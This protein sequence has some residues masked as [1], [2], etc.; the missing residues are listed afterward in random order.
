MPVDVRTPSTLVGTM[1]YLSE[2]C[3]EGGISTTHS[4]I[5]D[6]T[7]AIR[8]DFTLQNY[9]GPEAVYCHELIARF[10]IVSLHLLASKTG[11]E[12]SQEMEQLGKTLTSLAGFYNAKHREFSYYETEPEFRAY[13]IIM[14][15]ADADMDA[16][17]SRLPRVIREHPLVQMAMHI[18]QLIESNTM[19]SRFGSAPEM[20]QSN[21]V[22]LFSFVRNDEVPPLL[23]CMVSCRFQD[24]RRRALTKLCH[25]YP[26]NS[27]ALTLTYLRELLMYPD[28]ESLMKELDWYQWKMGSDEG[29]SYII[30]D[31][32]FWPRK[33]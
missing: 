20:T 30:P 22:A 21:E 2:L 12:E 16:A 10:H 13:S 29:T 9:S 5:R 7:R 32:T 11:F 33:Y 27:K 25:H 4:Y 17:V 15:H 24:M 18:R 3:N 28:E 31:K 23:R 6:R 26:A 19:P 1:K 8:K 14:N